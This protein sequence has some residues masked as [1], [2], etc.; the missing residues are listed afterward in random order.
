MRLYRAT[1]SV[2]SMTRDSSPS[3][4]LPFSASSQQVALDTW[5][6]C[7]LTEQN[8]DISLFIPQGKTRGALDVTAFLS[9]DE[10]T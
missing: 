9:G 1:P 5:A 6:R 8:A 7:T 3:A 10:S 2:P 4:C